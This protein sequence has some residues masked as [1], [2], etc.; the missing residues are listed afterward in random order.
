[1]ATHSSSFAWR[2]PWTEEPGGLQSIGWQRVGHDG[3][4]TFIFIAMLWQFLLYSKVIQLY[5]YTY[6]HTFFHVLFHYELSQDIEYKLYNRTQFIHTL[7][8]HSHQLTPNS[9]PTPLSRSPHLLGNCKPVLWVCESASALQISSSV[10]CKMWI[11][12]HKIQGS[13][14]DLRLHF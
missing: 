13:Q 1:M 10:T 9:S 3:L 4:T 7:C 5:I 6:T 12:I 8:N 14:G 11:L 2:I